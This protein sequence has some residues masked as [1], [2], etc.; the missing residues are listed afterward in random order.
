MNKSNADSNFLEEI[1]EW[2]FPKIEV[3][4]GLENAIDP[5]HREA[6]EAPEVKSAEQ[7]KLEEELIE[8]DKIKKEYQKKNDILTSILNKLSDPLSVIDD[9]LIDL[10]QEIIKAVV[11]NIIGTEIQGNP[12]LLTKLINELKEFL[13]DK[14]GIINV[15][16]S[17]I[18]FNNIHQE[19]H[20]DFVVKMDSSLNQGDIVIKS[21][22]AEIRMLLTERMDKMLGIKK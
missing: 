3:N 2:I 10:F 8:V 15:L 20:N 18:D 13:N 6:Q 17:E 11:K 4:Y 12:E 7:I 1:N 9:S 5:V 22:Y 14:S 19:C 21:N 16:L